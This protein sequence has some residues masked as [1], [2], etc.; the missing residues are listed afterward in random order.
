MPI[1][2]PAIMAIISG[3]IG[4]GSTAYSIYESQN[5]PGLPK[6]APAPSGPT[7]QQ[8]QSAIAPQATTIESQTGG[9]VSPEYLST[10]APVLAGVAGQP[11]TP[12]AMA[13]ILSQILGSGSTPS[14]GLSPGGT[15]LPTN[16]TASG[17]P[18]NLSALASTPGASDYLSKVAGAL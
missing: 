8:A 1:G 14:A 6:T 7:T 13:A 15:G 9:S 5:Q 17:L 2:I 12:A 4:A 10:V 16:F 11:N 18:T 3:V